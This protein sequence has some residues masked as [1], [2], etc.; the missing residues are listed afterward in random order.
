M[1]WKLLECTILYE[2][3]TIGVCMENGNVLLANVI[4]FKRCLNNILKEN[5][6]KKL[7]KLKS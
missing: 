4:C 7:G 5:D 6:M 2:E 3:G 1:L